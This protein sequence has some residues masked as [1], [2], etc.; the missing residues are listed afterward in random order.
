MKASKRMKYGTS[1]G[2]AAAAAGAAAGAAAAV[3]RRPRLG[4]RLAKLYRPPKSPS[5]GVLTWGKG[6]FPD[7]LWTEV[8]YS[9]QFTLTCTAGAA[10]SYQFSMNG[11]FD[12]NITGTGTQPR[13]F[14]TLCGANNTSA[15]YR[16]YLVKAA[17]VKVIAFPTGPDTAGLPCLVAIST[18]APAVTAP[19]TVTEIMQRNDTNYS[20]FGYYAGGKPICTVTRSG[21]VA[22]IL[23]AKSIED[24]NGAQAIYSSNPTNSPYIFVSVAPLNQ[25]TAAVVNLNIEIRYW[26]KFYVLND[27]ADS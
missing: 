27:V 3:A 12:P 1:R 7:N 13:Y 25:T 16:A 20:Y 19:T 18:C 10:Q 6:P 9:D 5:T 15:P 4:Q 2:A 24:T 23:G 14:D 21:D 17:K 26:V 11:L 8:V 22:T